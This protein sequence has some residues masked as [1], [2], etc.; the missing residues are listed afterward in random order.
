MVSRLTK[1]MIKVI[2]A[3]MISARGLRNV[4]DGEVDLLLGFDFNLRGKLGTSFFPSYM[5]SIDRVTGLMNVNLDGFIPSNLIAAP[6]G[7]THFKISS[8]GTEI[9]FELETFT[10]M[11]SE[12][13]I[14]PWDAVVTDPISLINNLPPGGTKPM[15]LVLGVEFFQ[16]INGHKYPLKNGVFNP[17]AIVKVDSG[18]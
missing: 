17:L 15:F 4:I 12:S 7:T 10:E 3:D 14:L 11:H 5:A 8:L 16:E 18:V 9:D 6:G 13:D 1:V 2:Q